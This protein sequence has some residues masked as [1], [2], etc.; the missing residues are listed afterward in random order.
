MESTAGIM[1]NIKTCCIFP[2]ITA[3]TWDRM[4]SYAIAERTIEIFYANF[5]L[6][7]DECDVISPQWDTSR[8]KT[9]IRVTTQCQHNCTTVNCDCYSLP[10]IK[11]DNEG[12]EQSEVPISHEKAAIIK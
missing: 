2:I 6:Y 5:E 10:S 1:R 8:E 12:I 3:K 9:A 7:N 4:I 11:I